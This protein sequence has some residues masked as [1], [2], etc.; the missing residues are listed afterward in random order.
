MCHSIVETIKFYADN[1]DLLNG[2]YIAL[3]FYHQLT[4][5]PEQ[6]FKSFLSR[7]LRSYYEM[8]QKLQLHHKTTE[9][10]KFAHFGKTNIDKEIKYKPEVIYE[11]DKKLFNSL[12]RIVC[13][14]CL[15][16]EAKCKG[17]KCTK[18]NNQQARCS[19]CQLPVEGMFI[20]CQVCSHG[21][22]FEHMQ[23][24]FKTNR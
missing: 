7:I 19:V 10:A 8:L 20:W 2:A 12:V 11:E 24:W 9:L 14:Y 22:H 6:K 1:G 3:I 23:S 17:S 13:P 5:N 16:V 4:S 15:D 18:C 21:G